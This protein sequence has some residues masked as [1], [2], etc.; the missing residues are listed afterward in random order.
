MIEKLL[1]IEPLTKEKISNEIERLILLDVDIIDAVLTV[2]KKYELTEEII[3][4]QL[5]VNIIELVTMQAQKTKNIK[6]EEKT[7]LSDFSLED[8][9]ENI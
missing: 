6:I 5:S 1:K 4:K 2:A 3:A 7:T 8:F 9:Q